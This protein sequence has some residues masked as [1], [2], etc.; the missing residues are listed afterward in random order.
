MSQRKTSQNG[1]HATPGWVPGWAL[2]PILF[3]LAVWL[4]ASG[5]LT[6]IPHAATPPF[7]HAALSTAPRRQILGDPPTLKINDF[8][9][10]CMDCHKIFKTPTDKPR[11]LNQH[12]NIHMDHGPNVKCSTCH[13]WDDRNRLVRPDGVSIPFTQVVDQCGQCHV[14][15]RY[16]WGYGIHGR[17]NGYWDPKS[18]PQERRIC[19]ECHDP[20]NPKSPAMDPI[21]PLPGP[22]TLRL[23]NPHGEHD[24]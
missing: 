4:H 21:S 18:G 2:G 6:P 5:L 20:H 1:S 13:D 3:A 8:D 9:R 14:R 22:H 16:D 15:I 12:K 7:D 17:T 19:T 10:T 11:P 24:Q 23:T